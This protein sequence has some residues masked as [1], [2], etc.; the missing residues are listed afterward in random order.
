MEDFINYSVYNLIFIAYDNF[1]QVATY[2]RSCTQSK[3]FGTGIKA[4]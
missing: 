1:K 2:F 3:N 4:K